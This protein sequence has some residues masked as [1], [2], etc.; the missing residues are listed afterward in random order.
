MSRGRGPCRG[1][2]TNAQH[3]KNTTSRDVAM[4]ARAQVFTDRDVLI[5]KYGQAYRWWPSPGS[6]KR[7]SQRWAVPSVDRWHHSETFEAARAA[8]MAREAA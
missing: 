8:S 1:P 7:G 2:S 6:R 4:P 5:A 3:L